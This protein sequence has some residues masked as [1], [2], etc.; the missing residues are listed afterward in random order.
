MIQGAA[1]AAP[2][3]TEIDHE[4]DRRFDHLQNFTQNRIKITH[5]GV[6]AGIWLCQIIARDVWVSEAKTIE[7]R[8][9]RTVEPKQGAE[10]ASVSSDAR[11]LCDAS[12]DVTGSEFNRER[13]CRKALQT[14]TFSQ[15]QAKQKAPS[16]EA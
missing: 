1:F 8:F 13:K 15:L 4:L 16:K 7:Y 14:L 12:G 2:C 9:W 11:R 6:C 3:N 10:G 5:R